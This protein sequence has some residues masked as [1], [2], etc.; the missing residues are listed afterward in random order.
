[1]PARCV[2][3]NEPAAEPTPARRLFWH[4]RIYFA[5][6]LVSV[7]VYV[8]VALIVRRKA[9]VSPG[10]CKTHKRRR[11]WFLGLAWLGFLGFCAMISVFEAIDWYRW[12]SLEQAAFILTIICMMVGALGARMVFP[13][14]IGPEYVRLRGCG[15]PFLNS[16]PPFAT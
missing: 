1:M 5:L 13:A 15:D 2:K 16:L 14:S 10:L 6:L 3:C 11:R 12:A 8:V 7:P 4:P 9:V